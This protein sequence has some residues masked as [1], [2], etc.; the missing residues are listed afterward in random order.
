MIRKDDNDPLGPIGSRFEE[1]LERVTSKLD[2]GRARATSRLDREIERLRTSPTPTH[3][4]TR[5]T[6]ASS[7]N[8]FVSGV[9]WMGI[10]SRTRDIIAANFNELLDQADDPA[11]MIRM[12]ILEMEETLVE[13][14]ASAARTIADQK[15]M[16]RHC[17]KLDKCED[18][19]DEEAQHALRHDRG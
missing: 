7:A 1:K 19:W 3:P 6:A 18:D 2:T 14:R 17:G 10:F 16:Q 8:A 12:I 13:V 4:T 15:E 5:T 11:K 9:P